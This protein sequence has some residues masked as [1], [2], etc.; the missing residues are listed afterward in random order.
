MQVYRGKLQQENSYRR[1]IHFK[2][3]LQRCISQSGKGWHLP[4]R[5]KQVQ[6]DPGCDLQWNAH[7]QNSWER[8]FRSK[9]N[10]QKPSFH[11]TKNMAKIII[12]KSVTIINTYYS[13]QKYSWNF[14]NCWYLLVKLSDFKLRPL[15]G[16]TYWDQADENGEAW[17]LVQVSE[18][19][20]YPGATLFIP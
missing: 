3:I 14:L 5:H 11:H 16:I 20:V 15:R 9:F 8:N 12:R 18:Y 6:W 2:Q 1:L 10:F 17:A 4:Q 13:T 19:L 7:V